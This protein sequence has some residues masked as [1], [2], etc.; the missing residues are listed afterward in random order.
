MKT[1][2]AFLLTIASLTG[3][4]GAEMAQLRDENRRLRA[5]QSDGWQPPG[6]PA[7][8][9]QSPSAPSVA[10]PTVINGNPVVGPGG[11]GAVG[12]F[13][14]NGQASNGVMIARGKHGVYMGT[15][16][17]QPRQVTQGVKLQLPNH[18]CDN[19]SRD[20]TGQCAD[21]DSNGVQDYNT[22]LAF[23]I[24]GQPV[25]CDSGYVHPDTGEALLPPGQTCFVELG[26]SLKVTL[27][28]RAY[29]NSGTPQAI[30]LDPA[31]DSSRDHAVNATGVNIKYFEIDESRSR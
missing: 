20:W 8:P 21:A 23:Q 1:I 5:A 18:V 9:S 4:Y 19:G 12:G 16:G 27:T 14:G 7:I 25:V 13:A 3:C 28:V 24:D 2:I 22:W 31:P 6:H 26:R 11:L 10:G 29:R 30:M 15:V 17:S